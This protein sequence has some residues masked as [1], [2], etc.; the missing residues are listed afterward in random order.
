MSEEALLDI[1]HKRW[2]EKHQ[3]WLETTERKRARQN[4][5]TTMSCGGGCKGCKGKGKGKGKGGGGKRG[6]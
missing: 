6:R 4:G 5:V 2:T 1:L 3:Q